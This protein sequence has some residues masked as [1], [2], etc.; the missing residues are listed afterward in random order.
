MNIYNFK[1]TSEGHKQ[2]T[3]NSKYYTTNNNVIV[4]RK[5]SLYSKLQTSLQKYMSNHSKEL[6]LQ[7]NKRFLGKS[8]EYYLQ[9]K[10]A[11]MIVNLESNQIEMKENFEDSSS[12]SNMKKRAPY[13][14]PSKT[15][16]VK[17]LNLKKIDSCEK[18]VTFTR[19]NIVRNNNLTPI[20]LIQKKKIKNLNEKFEC[21]KAER[22]AV[23]LRRIEY[24]N[25]MKEKAMTKNKTDIRRNN[26][27]III[28][29]WYRAILYRNKN[30]ILLQ[31]HIR[32][33]LARKSITELISYANILNL[34]LTKLQKSITIP[35]IKPF[36]VVIYDNFA[37]E[38]QANDFLKIIIF[39]Q[40]KIRKYFKMKIHKN[41]NLIKTIKKIQDILNKKKRETL[42][43]LKITKVGVLKRQ[44]WYFKLNKGFELIHKYSIRR[45]LYKLASFARLNGMIE[46][47]LLNIKQIKLRYFFR[48]M[49]TKCVK[50]ILFKVNSI[51]INL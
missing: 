19:K 7:G 10:N 21:T 2:D 27:A 31:A 51:I 46:H 32:G 26:A 1:F 34:R 45:K 40:K 42:K 29:N 22:T 13:G 6:T 48:L 15:N 8:G 35:F 11:G 23:Q 30:L 20:P 17:L 37:L 9:S 41:T 49:N 38:S 18:V 14:A 43:F 50:Y 44:K 28:Q 16:K 24:A 36:F 5:I 3:P 39:L 33:Y 12:F 47:I 4:D 25:S